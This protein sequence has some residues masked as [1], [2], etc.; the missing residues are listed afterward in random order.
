MEGRGGEGK[1]VR[2]GEGKGGPWMA[3]VDEEKGEKKEARK[4]TGQKAGRKKK[5][6]Q[7]E[8]K[9]EAEE[10]GTGR[11]AEE[12]REERE[13]GLKVLSGQGDGEGRRRR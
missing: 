12:W 11:V 1:T 9:N 8:R 6:G 3:R 13:K 5:R 7:E 2:G 4:K 10:R